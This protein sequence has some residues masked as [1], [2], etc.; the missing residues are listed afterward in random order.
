MAAVQPWTHAK[1]GGPQG[2]SRAQRRQQQQVQQQAEAGALV[3][4]TVITSFPEHLRPEVLANGVLL[5]DKPPH[6][7]VP[8]VVA[9]VQRATGADKVASVAPLDARASGLMLLCF[10]SATRL[11]PRVE[12]AAKRYT[13]TLV[14]GGSSL[15]G[16]VRGGSFRAAQLPAEHLTDEDLR[17]A[18]QGLVTA[19]AGAPVHGAVAT[20][21]QGGGGLALRVL[22][23]TWRLRQ[24][25]S[26][27]EYYEERVEPSMRTLDME[28]LD[29]RVWRESALSHNDGAAG[30]EY[31]QHDQHKQELGRGLVWTR[32]PPHPRPV[33]LRFSALLVGRSHV[34]SLI[35]MYGRRLRTAACLDD[36]RRTEIGSFNVE[37]AWPLEALVPVLQRHAH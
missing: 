32:S 12:R 18:A 3:V 28:L 21:H 6:W 36:L 17:E 24:L 26:S 31:D 7:E 19:A 4:P 30:A 29:F 25:P 1:A 27:T 5:V 9:A 11:A 22:P 14:L 35:A 15:S 33:V 13:G 10:G 23:R 34:R 20:G 8:E 2:I 16:D 37:E